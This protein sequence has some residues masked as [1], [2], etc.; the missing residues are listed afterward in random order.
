MTASRRLLL[1]RDRELARL[2]ELLDAARAGRGAVAVLEGAAGIGKTALVNE[3]VRRADGAGLSVVR[4]SGAPLEREY[5]FGV[6]RQAFGRVVARAGRQDTLFEGAA[7]L[8]RVPLGLRAGPLDDGA[9]M[10]GLYWLTVNSTEQAPIMLAVDDAHCADEMS[11][12]FAVYLARRI[13]D[14]PVLLLIAARPPL[15]G[16]PLGALAG[17]E[18]T[19]W[20]RPAPLTEADVARLIADDGRIDAGREF[21]AACHRAS[22][23][24]PFLVGEL[25]AAARSQ[26]QGRAADIATLA[27]QG[28]VRWVLARVRALGDDA[29]RLASALAVLGN[30]AAL[31]DAAGL[32]GL[33]RPAAAASADALIAAQILELEDGYRFVHPL[34]A[35]ALEEGLAPTEKAEAHA[36]AARLAAGR[37]APNA[38]V[39]AH[40]LGSQPARDEWAVTILSAAAD[41]AE[42]SGAPASAVAYLQRAL[43]EQSPRAN[44]AE[45]MVRLGTAQ[46][47]AG[48]T[49]AAETLRAA[50]E[51]EPDPHRRASIGL[52]LGRARFLTGDHVGARDA[53]RTALAERPAVDD[54]LSRELGAWLVSL[55]PAA[56]GPTDAGRAW[57]WALLAQDAPGAT[58]IERAALAH[59]AYEGARSGA[60]AHEAIVRLALRALADGALLDDT[61]T[62]VGPYIGTCLALCIAGRPDEVIA[63]QRVAIERSQRRGSVLAF[64]WF[65]LARGVAYSERGELMNALADFESARAPAGDED[66]REL[67]AAIAFRANCQLERGDLA[68]AARTLQAIDDAQFTATGELCAQGRLQA[69]NGQLREALAT[70]LAAGEAATRL[71]FANPA[72]NFA[73]RSE[74]ALV[75]AR[76]GEPRRAAELAAEEL[77]LARAFGAPRALGIAL[78]GAG[79]VERGEEGLALLAE[80]VAV[81]EGAEA[82]LELGRALVELG[83]AQRRAGRRRD[84][85]EPLVR[86][87]DLVSRCGATVLAARAR[88]E[89][90]AAGARPRRERISGAASL[91]ASELRVARL[92][93]D[94][95][96]K[97]EIA[98]ALFVSMSTV[99]THLGHVYSKLGVN[100]RAGLAS[101][102][103]AEPPQPA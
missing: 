98:Q 68:G 29:H 20:L 34:L 28:V 66:D 80:A 3:A 88:D 77:R 57:L 23:G 5:A 1:G 7:E 14:L 95:L 21:V 11:L 49:G 51:A 62:D 44:R 35:S 42:A 46:L 17:L 90:V 36:R 92:A 54:D 64:R 6:V 56:E 89:L 97:R 93:R 59:V 38:E 33:D 91:T 43:E 81:L 50:R 72:A 58:P 101:A 70:L 76:L 69:A 24:N 86:G 55:D 30:G 10:H 63:R 94:G 74:A 39:A 26:A 2:D 41:E 31:V 18:R 48:R 16:G 60:I 8:A 84:A 53:L 40:L 19:T 100:S 37:E 32:A 12:Q 67:P 73:W 9:A 61:R 27:P 103:S 71:N 13:D 82:E 102:L 52:A 99:S 65:S 96:T 4:S 83:A 22:G 25:L 87:L 79:L 15:A 78:R 45:L 75:S 47:H 85:R